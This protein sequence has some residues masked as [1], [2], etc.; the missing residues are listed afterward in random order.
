MNELL[1]ILLFTF[2]SSFLS[3]FGGILLLLKEKWTIKVSSYFVN[4]AIGALLGVSFLDLLPE[5]FS[6]GATQTISIFIIAGMIL[7]YLLEK[8]LIWH[9]HHRH[10]GEKE[11]HSFNYLVVLGD[12]IHNFFD[13]VAVATAFLVA[14]PLG[15]ITSLAVF[16]HEVPQEIGNF[17]ILLY[18]GWRR[19][20]VLL[21]NVVVSL[22]A[23]I[24]A[25]VAYFAFSM[26]EKASSYVLAFV[27]GTF[28]YIASADLLPETKRELKLKKSLLQIAFLIFGVVVILI[29]SIMTA[30]LL[31][32]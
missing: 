2:F 24:G 10:Y 18:G 29:T 22:T 14:F 23:F 19:K 12:G 1:L 11:F 15:I 31:G 27:A 7:F 8:S 32:V 6:K 13:G 25:F 30:N 5:A 9:H 20:K 21:Y 4:F 3:L 16:F 17:S 26:I 28:I